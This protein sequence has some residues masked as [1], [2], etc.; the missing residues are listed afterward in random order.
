MGFNDSLEWPLQQLHDSLRHRPLCFHGEKRGEV[1]STLITCTELG[2]CSWD[3]WQRLILAYWSIL[4]LSTEKWHFPLLLS[5]DQ[6]VTSRND[7]WQLPGNLCIG[8]SS[9]V[10]SSPPPT[11]LTPLNF[12]SFFLLLRMLMWWLEL[13]Q[14]LRTTRCKPHVEDNRVL[15]LKFESL[16]TTVINLRL[17][18]ARLLI[19]E[20]KKYYYFYL[21]H[22]YFGFFVIDK[23]DLILID[24]ESLQALSITP[25]ILNEF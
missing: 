1:V 4:S 15:R 21:K 23:P 17:L 13:E 8:P 16:S 7:V 5:L 11:P 24:K 20:R 14:S 2:S 6:C 22:C 25:V 3:L 9:G 12:P 10:A 19:F 18:T